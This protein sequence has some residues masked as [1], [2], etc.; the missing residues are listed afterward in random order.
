MQQVSCNQTISLRLASL[1][2]Q[3]SQV[4]QPLS[5]WNTTAINN[6]HN[7]LLSSHITRQQLFGLSADAQQENECHSWYHDT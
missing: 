1:C 2:T 6:H 3:P 4:P 7:T 5:L